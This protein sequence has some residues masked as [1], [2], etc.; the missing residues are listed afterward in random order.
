M[1]ITMEI[2]QHPMQYGR[3]GELRYQKFKEHGF[4]YATFPMSNTDM[5]WYTLPQEEADALLLKEK[6]LALAA[7]VEYVNAHGPWRWPP[8]DNTAEDRAERLEKMKRS[9]HNTH[10]LGAKYWVVH[11]IMPFGVED[12]GTEQAA[13]TEEINRAFM[14]ELLET[15]K[16]EDVVICLENMPM[17]QFS[18][19]TPDDIM[20]VVERIDDEHFA[21]CLDTGHVNV[22]PELDIGDSVRRM[23]QK[24][25]VIHVHDNKIERDLHLYPFFG[26]L[27]WVSFSR[28]LRE[29]GFDGIFEM[30]VTVP[31]IPDEAFFAEHMRM[32]RKTADEVC[33]LAYK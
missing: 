1:K 11:P 30:E 25:Q 28:A 12:L 26:T 4:D 2:N 27:D 23:G 31:T 5:P 17:P 24:M 19:S 8:K 7:G 18:I 33:G 15:A 16:Q 32:I 10:V 29:T 21:A 9:I 3:Y 6:E 20:Q 22:Y 14:P 13:I